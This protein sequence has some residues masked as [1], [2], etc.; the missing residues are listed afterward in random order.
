[1]QQSEHTLFS[2]YYQLA[3][4]QSLKYIYIYMYVLFKARVGVFYQI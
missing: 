3:G 4:T 2:L 1:M